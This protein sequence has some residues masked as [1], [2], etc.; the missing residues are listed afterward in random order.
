MESISSIVNIF[1]G[2]PLFYG[3]QNLQCNF[4]S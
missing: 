3:M 1:V 4:N 2:G